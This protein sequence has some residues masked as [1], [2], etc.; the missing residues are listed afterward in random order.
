V[1]QKGSRVAD[2][3]ELRCSFCHKPEQD[4]R[5]LIAGPRVFICDECIEACNDIIADETRLRTGRASATLECAICQT[6]IDAV[7]ATFIERAGR[8][9]CAACVEAVKACSVEDS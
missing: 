5:K 3:P 1:V 4:V 8:T 2:K 7:D 6:Q 9:I